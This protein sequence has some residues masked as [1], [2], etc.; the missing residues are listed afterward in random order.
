MN[1]FDRAMKAIEKLIAR[2]KPA[3]RK[4]RTAPAP[5]KSTPPTRRM[6]VSPA[7]RSRRLREGQLRRNAPVDPLP[8]NASPTP[9]EEPGPITPVVFLPAPAH[10]ESTQAAETLPPLP[11]S[12]PHWADAFERSGPRPVVT[13]EVSASTKWSGTCGAL[14]ADCGRTCKLPAHPN[15]PDRHRHERGPFF[16]VAL[17][18]SAPFLQRRQ[19]LD[20]AAVRSVPA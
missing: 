19:M 1:A 20:E 16:R 2:G 6:K 10:S 5:K 4:K 15:D 3:K 12:R 7:E 13:P 18:G 14:D 8:V 17:S 11:V 9:P